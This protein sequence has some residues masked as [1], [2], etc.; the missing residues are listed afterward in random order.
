[1]VMVMTMAELGHNRAEG[2]GGPGSAVCDGME[3]YPCKSHPVQ[4]HPRI[5]GEPLSLRSLG[6]PEI[7]NPVISLP[8]PHFQANNGGVITSDSGVLKVCGGVGVPTLDFSAG[9]G[10]VLGIHPYFQALR[11]VS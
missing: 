11:G 4:T 7:Y 3:S 1:M 6:V 9:N 10:G 5:S 8:F 2:G